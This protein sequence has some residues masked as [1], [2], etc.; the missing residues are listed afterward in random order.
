MRINIF[1]VSTML[2]IVAIFLA[3][4]SAKRDKKYNIAVIVL[5]VV[6]NILY[7]LD[8]YLDFSIVLC[9]SII[10]NSLVMVLEGMIF[11]KKKDLEKLYGKRYEDIQKEIG[12]EKTITITDSD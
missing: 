9:F 1:A 4:Y 3:F 2:L 12:S 5:L 6:I 8:L 7:L 10:M 11:S